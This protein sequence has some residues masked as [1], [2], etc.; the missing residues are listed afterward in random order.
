MK[1]GLRILL[2]LAALAA[3][4]ALAGLAWVLFTE[5]GLRWAIERASAAT[6]GNLAIEGASGTLGAGVAF[7]RVVYADAGLRAEAT[8]VRATARVLPLLRGRI[9]IEPLSIEVLRIELADAGS[10]AE[11]APAVLPIGLRLADVAIDRLDLRAGERVERLERLRFTHVVVGPRTLQIGG[12]LVRPDARW[13]VAAQVEVK[14][15]L[16]RFEASAAGT[17]AGV[18]ARASLVLEPQHR[19]PVRAL[20]ARAGPVDP[21]GLLA[22]LPRAALSAQLRARAADD[23]YRGD[24][25]LENASPATLDAGGLPLAAARTR[26]TSRGL[27][28]ARLTQLSLQLAGG[29]MLEG[30]GVLDA[31]GLLAS[32]AARELDL[33]ALR[34]N[35]R[36]TQLRGE[37]DL[38]LAPEKQS[39]RGALAQEDISV[40]AHVERAGDLIEVRELHARAAGG[41]ARG[42]GRIRLGKRVAVQ[43]NLRVE[44]FDPAAFGDFPRGEIHGRLEADGLLGE[45]PRADARWTIERST[46][47][48]R[49][50]ESRG[51]ARF[52]AGRVTQAQADARYGPVRLSARGAFGANGDALNLS[53]AVDRLQDVDPRL[54]GRLRAEGTLT[55]TW[56]DPALQANA[57]VPDLRLPGD[58]KAR[59]ASATFEGTMRRHEAAL[60]LEA[61]GSRFHARLAGSWHGERGWQGEIAALE[62]AGTYPL[63]LLA[64]APLALARDRVELGK[65]EAQIAAGRMLVHEARWSP[66]RIA[67][68][69]EVRGLPLAWLALAAGEAEHLRS[70]MLLDGDWQLEAREVPVGTVRLRRASGDLALRAEG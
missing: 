59:A 54:R 50:L 36:R 9:G 31:D 56:A 6:G 23:G 15:S 7:D 5:P 8:R 3:S 49:A 27:E 44:R 67:T 64:P 28:R 13:P 33:R 52:T 21:A 62:N 19:Q 26:F 70:S 38:R 34:S 65:L 32:L 37:L 68:R 43:A 45:A 25:S 4:L 63:R 2:A 47:A 48:G 60:R 46:L 17:V 1:R 55:G 53:V 16:R 24:F 14:G 39:V 57:N 58:D 30:E 11:P 69:G 42:T 61:P 22:D 40:A 20:E 35:L 66:G 29:G 51:R 12:S 41:E 18:A 10:S